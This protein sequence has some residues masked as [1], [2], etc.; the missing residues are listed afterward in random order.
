MDRMYEGAPKLRSIH[1][2]VQ[3]F[4]NDTVAIKHTEFESFKLHI[5]CEKPMQ[6]LEVL[7]IELEKL[8]YIN[9]SLYEQ[10]ILCEFSN[11]KNPEFNR[12]TG[13]MADEFSSESSSG[14]YLPSKLFKT[15]VLLEHINY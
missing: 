11:C 10:S 14:I 3:L 7:I 1:P 6:P 4:A 9:N 12:L 2:S 13:I 8:K 5:V 15:C